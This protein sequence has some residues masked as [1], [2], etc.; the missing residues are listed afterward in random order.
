MVK[1]TCDVEHDASSSAIAQAL[2][3]RVGKKHWD[4]NIYDDTFI[5]PD[6]RQDVSFAQDSTVMTWNYGDLG[7]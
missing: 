6:P 4:V 3:V 7:M 1:F 2:T 5:G